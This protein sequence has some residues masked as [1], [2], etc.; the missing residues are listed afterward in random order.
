MRLS[1][2]LLL[3]LT[4]APVVHSQG[5]LHCYG[6]PN[7]APEPLR[8]QIGAYTV[9]IRGVT[10]TD[11][12]EFD[13]D[14]CHARVLS[15]A[16]ALI[17][18]E[19]ATGVN[20]L[21]VSGQDL[22]GDGA[23][24]LV[25]ERSWGDS[26]CSFGYTIL[27]LANPPQVLLGLESQCAFEFSDLDGDGRIELQAKDGVFVSFDDLSHD[28]SP[29]PSLYLRFEGSELH[30]VSDQFLSRYDEEIAAA[31]S[32]LTALR[33]RA[34][35]EAHSPYKDP[36]AREAVP[37][38]LSVVLAYFSSGRDDEAWDALDELWPAHDA[39]RIRGLIIQ[40]RESGLLRC[41]GARQC[42][43]RDEP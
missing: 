39:A 3:L 42:L 43:E 18:E 38:A 4:L 33:R 40:T 26:I 23:P 41:L 13:E 25:L 5:D 21:E 19:K 36:D 29:L 20:L 11:G 15:A 30:D 31:R 17:L 37:H 12:G 14:M 16:G 8:R 34:L 10:N 22:N 1:A 27:S 2:L 28:E 35:R 9:E 32:E 24:E 6:G 7:S